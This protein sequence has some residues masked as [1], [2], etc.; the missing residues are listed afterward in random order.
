MNSEA[1]A[2]AVVVMPTAAA[3]DFFEANAVVLAV[4]II[5]DEFLILSFAVKCIQSMPMN[6]PPRMAMNSLILRRVAMMTAAAM[7]ASVFVLIAFS[8]SFQSVAKMIASTAGLIPSIKGLK[9][10]CWP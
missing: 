9:L 8:A 3:I 5:A 4:I 10:G 1:P 7:T 6:P 2:I